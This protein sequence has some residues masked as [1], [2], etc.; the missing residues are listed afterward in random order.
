MRCSSNFLMQMK[1]LCVTFFCK[2]SINNSLAVFQILANSLFWTCWF[3][4]ARQFSGSLWTTIFTIS[5]DILSS[6]GAFLSLMQ[7]V[8]LFKIYLPALGDVLVC[9][10]MLWELFFFFMTILYPSPH[11]SSSPLLSP[12]FT[13]ISLL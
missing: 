13:L 7:L 9:L 10:F 3:I 2:F 6:P 11:G 1:R 8:V 12:F 4:T 5:G